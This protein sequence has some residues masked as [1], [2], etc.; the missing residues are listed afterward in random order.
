MRRRKITRLASGLA[1]A[2]LTAAATA[3]CGGGG[4]SASGGGTTLEIWNPEADEAEIAV[5]Q[6]M[7]DAY[8]EDNPDVKVNLVTVPWADIFTKWQTALQSGNPPDATIGSTPFAASFQAQGVLQPVDDVVEKIGGDDAWAETASTMVEMSQ[9]EG[10]YFNLPYVN[11]CVVL[12]YNKSMFEEAGLKPPT[13]WDEMEAAAA[14]LTHDDQYGILIPSSASQVTNQS[15]YSFILSNGG[16]IVDRDNPDTVTF[17]EPESVEALEFYTSLA[18]YSPPGSG[19]YDRP[20]AQAAM[21]TGKLGMFVYGSWMA[22]ALEEAGPEVAANFG[23]VPVP[24]KD[25]GPGGS[26]M[27]NLSL[28]AF[29]GS[30]HPEEAQEFLSYMYDPELYEEFVL[31]NPASFTPVLSE[32]QESETYLNDEKVKS[33]AE[34]IEA[35][36]AGLPNSWVFGMPNPHAGEWEGL[37]LIAEAV[38]AVVEQDEDPQAAARAVADQMRES[39]GN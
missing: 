13:T 30:E 3:A 17:D 38:N 20:E 27:G 8:E 31:L 37:N 10:S 39:I 33:Q 22:G 25:G 11:N 16:D 12:W 14:A 35:V 4:D 28:F 5:F 1:V 15:L 32:V 26:F 34:L 7:I 24:T 18:Q 21:T 29:K 9:D 36:R 19:G 23:V 6:K 2:A